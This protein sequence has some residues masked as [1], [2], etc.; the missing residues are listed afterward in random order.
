MPNPIEFAGITEPKSADMV[1]SLGDLPGIC[2]IECTPQNAPSGEG[3]LLLHDGTR[4]VGFPGSKIVHTS[5][6]IDPHGRRLP[7]MVVKVADRR[8]KWAS[9]NIVGDYNTRNTDGTVR[10]GA[11]KKNA[12]E[13][14]GILLDQ[15]GETTRDVSALPTNIYPRVAWPDRN[16]ARMLRVLCRRVGCDIAF[17]TSANV[18]IVQLGVGT[19]LPSNNR[20]IT[21]RV[22]GVP[23]WLPSKLIA[24]GS[25]LVV[26]SKLKLEAVG[27]DTDKKIKLINDLSYK[28][29][30]GWEKEWHVGFPSLT[31]PQERYL[32]TLSV[33][34]WYRLKG[35]ADGTLEVPGVEIDGTPVEI[36][37]VHQYHLLDD[38]IEAGKDIDDVNLPLPPYVVGKF[39][40]RGDD[41][42]T[43]AAGDRYPGRF[44]FLK[45]ER[46][47][48]FETPVV[49]IDSTTQQFKAAEL[50]LFTAYHVSTAAGELVRYRRELPLSAGDDEL[51]IEI[52]E[53]FYS[54]KHEYAGSGNNIVN[55]VSTQGTIDPE[56][57]AWLALFQTQYQNSPPALDMT[58]TGIE[59]IAADGL[60]PQ[61][62]WRM[63]RGEGPTTRACQRGTA[64]P[65]SDV[66]DHRDLRRA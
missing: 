14:A 7:T 45:A 63:P 43:T 29:A 41:A 4:S 19:A 58:Y 2:V 1:F 61:V 57:D 17:D 48:A 5:V 24:L 53:L 51:A 31:D 37:T 18:K 64:D 42:E 10:D 22:N 15:M 16:T 33:F 44:E 21:P 30:G 60:V 23:R 6:R 56:A 12:R 9:G 34:R 66:F 40:R 39:W 25:P 62:H 47:V 36:E 65:Y 55:T 27:L 28:P 8:H 35:Q 46:V 32:A 59:V 11:R 38:L 49:Q 13:L 50:Y 52:P 26:Q 20:E 3:T 54:L